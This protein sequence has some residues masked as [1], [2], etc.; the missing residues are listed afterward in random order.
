M[1]KVKCFK[2]TRIPTT[3]NCGFH[4]LFELEA[5]TAPVHAFF[6]YELLFNDSWNR[7]K[8]SGKTEGHSVWHVVGRWVISRREKQRSFLCVISW[9]LSVSIVFI[10]TVF[11]P[12]QL[13]F[14]FLKKEL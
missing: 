4:C 11:D 1:G 13:G 9:N 7:K 14:Y 6:F 5:G 3:N 2:R 10:T 12:E 8:V